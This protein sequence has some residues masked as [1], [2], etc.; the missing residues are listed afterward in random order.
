LIE[1]GK[2]RTEEGDI[3]R[4]IG[5][6]MNLRRCGNTHTLYIDLPKV[7]PSFQYLE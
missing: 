1:W 2:E 4:A 3:D 5:S 6:V 7:P